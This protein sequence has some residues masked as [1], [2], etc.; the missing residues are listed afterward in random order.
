[1]SYSSPI[2]IDFA[3]Q[4]QTVFFTGEG[5]VAVAPHDG[6]ILWQHAWPTDY[7]INAAT[8]VFVSPDKIFISTGYGVGGALVQLI[9]SDGKIT[10]K[11]IWKNKEMK[12]HF[13]TSVY[14]QGHLYGFDESILV[15]LDAATGKEKWKTRGYGKGSLII[16]DGHLV[17]LGDN[18]KLGIAQATPEAFREKTTRTVFKDKCWTNPSLANGR[19]YLRNEKEIVRLDITQ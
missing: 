17:I 11:E 1:M 15:C 19:I 6:Q 16:A 9:A 14:Y 10:T 4:R 18:G 7:K 5:L 2:G 3:D 12:N 8:P 13:A